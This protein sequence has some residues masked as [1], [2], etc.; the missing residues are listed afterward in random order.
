[1]DNFMRLSDFQPRCVSKN[2]TEPGQITEQ[3]TDLGTFSASSRS[4]F[5]KS[6]SI[7]T[8]NDILQNSRM[9]ARERALESL[10]VIQLRQGQRNQRAG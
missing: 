2:H 5:H 8:K 6:E 10:G 3:R 1:M 9:L 7:I 4:A